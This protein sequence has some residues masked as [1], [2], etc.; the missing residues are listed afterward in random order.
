MVSLFLLAAI[1]KDD[2]DAWFIRETIRPV[3][4][5][6]YSSLDHV[7][8]QSIEDACKFAK[9]GFWR[10]KVDLSS[11]Y[12]SVAIHPDDYKVTGLKWKFSG[13]SYLFDTVLFDARRGH[14][15]FHRI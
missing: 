6:D 1:P 15:I 14:A 9:P 2:R 3:G 8:F 7:M 5:N 10:V 11:A 12:C 13:Q 4:T